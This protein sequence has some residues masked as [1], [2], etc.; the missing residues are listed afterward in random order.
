MER[1]A[2]ALEK[3][4]TNGTFNK[5]LISKIKNFSKTKKCGFFKNSDLK[6]FFN[7]NLI[8]DVKHYNISL[9]LNLYIKQLSE[10]ISKNE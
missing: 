3:I 8:L 7:F 9:N 5:G 2:T 10:L 1:Q 4:F 6:P